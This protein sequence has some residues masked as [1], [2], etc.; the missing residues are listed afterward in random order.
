MGSRKMWCGIDFG[1]T[2]CSI[3]VVEEQNGGYVCIPLEV[4]ARIP[5]KVMRNAAL[6]SKDGNQVFVGDEAFAQRDLFNAQAQDYYFLDYYKWLLDKRN[7]RQTLLVQENNRVAIERT[8]FPDLPTRSELIQATGS[9][10][11]ALIEQAKQQI[12]API[13]GYIIGVP[14]LFS[15][16]SQRRIIEALVSERVFST[17]RQAIKMVR[18]VPEAVAAAMLFRPLGEGPVPML[19]FDFGG[20]SLDLALLEAKPD[21]SGHLIPSA[22]LAIGG[23]RFAGRHI[24]EKLFGEVVQKNPAYE[25]KSSQFSPYEQLLHLEQVEHIKQK[26][27]FEESICDYI[28]GVP[29]VFHRKRLEALLRPELSKIEEAVRSVVTRAGLKPSQVHHVVMVGGSSLIPCVQELIANLFPHAA[30]RGQIYHPKLAKQNSKPF[31]ESECFE[32]AITAISQGLSLYPHIEGLQKRRFS[33]YALWDAEQEKHVDVVPQNEPTKQN[34]VYKADL[35]VCKGYSRLTISLFRKSVDYEFL[36]NIVDIPFQKGKWELKKRFQVEISPLE[37]ALF[38]KIRLWDREKKLY[39]AEFDIAQISEDDFYRIFHKENSTYQVPK[40]V[41]LPSQWSWRPSA[42]LLEIGDVIKIVSI[43]GGERKESKPFLI[44]EILPAYQKSEGNKRLSKVESWSFS[45]YW[46]NSQKI[47][48]RDIQHLSLNKILIEERESIIRQLESIQRQG[49]I[50]HILGRLQTK[51]QNSP[52]T[53]PQ[54]ETANSFDEQKMLSDLS[55]TFAKMMGT[56]NSFIHEIKQLK[57]SLQKLQN[58]TITRSE[59]DAQWRFYEQRLQKLQTETE[60]IEYLQNELKSVQKNLESFSQRFEN[61]EQLSKRFYQFEQKYLELYHSVEEFHQTLKSLHQKFSNLKSQFEQE[62]KLSQKLEKCFQQLQKDFQELQKRWQNHLAQ[63]EQDLTSQLNEK[64]QQLYSA[65]SE[66]SQKVQAEKKALEKKLELDKSQWHQTLDTWKEEALEKNRILKQNLQ[67]LE[68]EVAQKIHQQNQQLEEYSRQ[69][70]L[71]SQENMSKMGSEVHTL[72]GKI[73]KYKKRS[74][75]GIAAI[76]VFVMLVSAML[77]GFFYLLQEEVKN[78]RTISKG[79]IAL[80]VGDYERAEE[81]FRQTENSLG[82][83]L[84]PQAKHRLISLAQASKAMQQANQLLA[85]GQFLK[86]EKKYRLAYQLF[87]KYDLTPRHI[88]ARIHRTQTFAQAEQFLKSEK[89][90]QALKIYRQIAEQQSDIPGGLFARTKAAQ[91]LERLK[92]KAL[93]A[94]QKGKWNRAH[95][96]YTKL[97][98]LYPKHKM[99]QALKEKTIYLSRAKQAYQ[100]KDTKTAREYLF[101]VGQFF[102]LNSMFSYIIWDFLQEGMQTLPQQEDF[103]HL[104]TK[105]LGNSS[106][107]FLE[108]WDFQ[109]L[110]ALGDKALA[111]QNWP[112]AYQYYQQAKRIFP[113]QNPLLEKRFEELAHQMEKSLNSLL[114]AQQ[115]KNAKLLLDMYHS[116]FPKKDTSSFK[117]QLTSIEWELQAKNSETQENFRLA[118]SQY[119]KAYSLFPRLSLK[120]KIRYLASI[121]LKEAI[122]KFSAALELGQFSLALEILQKGEP[123]AQD[124]FAYLKELFLQHRKNTTLFL[125]HYQKAEKFLSH[126]KLHLALKSY[127]QALRIYPSKFVARKKE[128]VF[129]K[130]QQ[131]YVH[132]MNLASVLVDQGNFEAAWQILKSAKLVDMDGTIDPQGKLM[133][134]R[135]KQRLILLSIMAKR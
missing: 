36:I 1:T 17:Y 105:L 31:L 59:F 7:L 87:S 122:D 133:V 84:D 20:G 121:L 77:G 73:Q 27:S 67:K 32:L 35:P 92:N 116:L 40:E 132:L 12:S 37:E 11:K 68:N 41:V 50:V 60:W 61:E 124:G 24:D 79:S 22:E 71:L 66:L 33:G 64:F 128:T 111:E 80:L 54:E 55:Q 62:K 108:Q 47:F 109:R 99:F 112:K 30:D 65:C 13:S 100:Q 38:P 85:D 107:L 81:Y 21:S 131:K 39:I 118:Y 26:L 28:G 75:A 23:L 93:E 103:R 76:A 10:L 5:F 2:N 90:F 96:I 9:V 45:K 126:G 88:L 51:N 44:T 42:K 104:W 72:R 48:N 57:N 101:K 91:I 69:L 130:L 56:Y 117:R 25:A 110:L 125:Q 46:I 14:T 113:Q 63:L 8:L 3:S 86:A 106:N 134:E 49:K 52:P 6:F 53:P 114:I 82:T 127:E 16:L 34:K 135:I 89:L 70:R 74:L 83:G 98:E 58:D 120:G 78:Q 123:F 18:F 97:L 4:S 94:L 129:K 115:V 43:E 15:H 19:V 119:K 29:F 95:K 102:Q